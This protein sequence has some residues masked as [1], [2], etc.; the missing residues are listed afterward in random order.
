MGL[1]EGIT[2]PRDLKRLGLTVAGVWVSES[3]A[4]VHFEVLHVAEMD[5]T[6]KEKRRTLGRFV[7][8]VGATFDEGGDPDFPSIVT[9]ATTELKAN[10]AKVGQFLS[11]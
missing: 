6:R 5:E 7:Q 2:F 3:L 8:T 1:M 4:E 9:E 10:L 11:Q